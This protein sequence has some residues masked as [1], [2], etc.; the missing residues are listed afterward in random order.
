MASRASGEGVSGR[1][2]EAFVGIDVGGSRCKVVVLAAD[3]RLVAEA[4]A[5]YTAQRSPD[6]AVTQDAGVLI[7]SVHDCVV[8]CQQRLTGW[9]I[10]AGSITAP[11]HAVVLVSADG[12][13]LAPILLPQDGRSSAIAEAQ[14]ADIGELIIARTMNRLT[15]GWTLPQLTWLSSTVPDLVQ[16]TRWILP[17]KDFIR[18]LLTGE[19]ATDATDAVGTAMYDPL[20]H[21]WVEDLIRVSGFPGNCFP[22]VRAALE[23]AGAVS[24]EGSRVSGLPK[25]IPVIVGGTDTANELLSLRASGGYRALLKLASTATAVAELTKA[26]ANPD[27]YTYPH[28]L[29]DLW[30]VVAPTNTAATALDWFR[31]TVLGFTGV[32]DVEYVDRLASEAPPG[33]DDLLFFPYLEGERCPYWNRSLRGTFLGMSTSHGMEHLCRAVLEGI[34]QSARDCLETVRA[35]GVSVDK[36]ALTGGGSNSAIWGAILASIVDIPLVRVDPS[37]PAVGATLLALQGVGY[38]QPNL[39]AR[40]HL[41]RGPDEWKQSYQR[42]SRRYREAADGLVTLTASL[43]E[44]D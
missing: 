26:A 40:E 39:L 10:V 18:F 25:G 14:E 44:A 13:P 1:P 24:S 34:A 37:G 5:R 28:V 7:A 32:S 12:W 38:S 19:P 27:V 31:S 9:R 8:R 21:E 3:G 35:Q 36:V 17:I 11:A 20:E 15:P 16:R 6:G 41:I 29:E 23:V 22:P 2:G 4:D 43:L 30:Y 33:S 42:Q